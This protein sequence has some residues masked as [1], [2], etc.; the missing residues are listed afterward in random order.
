MSV[1]VS[2]ELGTDAANTKSTAINRFLIAVW[3]LSLPFCLDAINTGYSY[4]FLGQGQ[5]PVFLGMGAAEWIPTAG[6]IGGNNSAF[7]LMIGGILCL[8]MPLQLYLVLNEKGGT[9]NASLTDAAVIFCWAMFLCA[10]TFFGGHSLLNDADA[11]LLHNHVLFQ[12]IAT[13]DICLAYLAYR[14]GQARL[15]NDIQ[16]YKEFAIRLFTL[17]IGIWLVRVLEGW[18]Q[19]G[20]GFGVSAD[21]QLLFN[22]WA[23]FILPLIGLQIYFHRQKTRKED[24]SKHSS[25][26]ALSWF[27]I[28]FIAIGGLSYYF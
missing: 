1:D 19:L 20:G 17:G 28:A 4:L 25:A 23:F 18:W 10:T 13:Y 9:W 5:P 8:I 24:D 21:A 14:T 3:L 22:S 15:K 6:A 7:H 11:V 12:S 26:A 27:G 2:N 16:Q